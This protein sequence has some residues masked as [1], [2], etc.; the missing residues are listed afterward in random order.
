MCVYVH[1]A[2]L[3]IPEELDDL[4]VEVGVTV[5]VVVAAPDVNDVIVVETDNVVL[6][7]LVDVLVIM[8]DVSI[9]R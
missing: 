5:E 3:Y 8:I 2:S 7:S 9:M 1:K 4:P 6:V